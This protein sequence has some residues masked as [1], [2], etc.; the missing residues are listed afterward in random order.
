MVTDLLTQN[1]PDIVDV[2]FTASMEDKL[3]AIAEGEATYV[4]V[5]TDF[6]KPFKA[7]VDTKSES[8][9]KVNTTVETDKVCP[10]CGAPML[11]RRG[12]FGQFLAC[13]RF[14]ECKTTQPL[15]EVPPTGLICPINGKPLVW[16]RARKGQFL[17]CSGYPD[18]KFALWKKEQLPAKITELEKEGTELP[19]KEQALQALAD[20]PPSENTEATG[21]TYTKRARFS[22]KAAGKT[23]KAASKSTKSS[24]KKP[25]AKKA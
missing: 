3:D 12:R 15:H 11:I 19:F 22:K 18:C 24:K 10:V 4:G 20:L 8:I 2:T 13:S 1:F 6:W 25:A 21:S 9:E 5:L 14:P 23:S 7:Q 16:K 17:G